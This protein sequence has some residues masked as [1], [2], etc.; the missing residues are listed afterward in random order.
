MSTD[1]ADSR[2]RPARFVSAD[3]FLDLPDTR[4][5]ELSD[6]AIVLTR[7]NNRTTWVAGQV[8]AYL[9]D[10]VSQRDLGWVLPPNTLLR[11]DPQ[12][13]DRAPTAERGVRRPP[14]VSRIRITRHRVYVGGPRLGRRGGLVA[15]LGLPSRAQAGRIPCRGRSSDLGCVRR[16]ADGIR[17]FAC[18]DDRLP[19]RRRSPRRLGRAAGFPRP[20]VGHTPAGAAGRLT[21]S[22]LGDVRTHG[23]DAA[24]VAGPARRSRPHL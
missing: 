13:P 17:T 5:L 1:L 4:G 7:R 14:P 19:H 3:E 16:D 18:R 11:C 21:L 9:R 12:H 24:V 10:F 6:G 8:H 23:Y 15:G 22:P 2:G 20:A